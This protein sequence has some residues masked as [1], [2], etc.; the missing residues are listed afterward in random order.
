MRAKI[1]FSAVAILNERVRLDS[2]RIENLQQSK[3]DLA[4]ALALCENTVSNDKKIIAGY[5]AIAKN[6]KRKWL[7]RT[8]YAGC[9]GLAAGVVVG[10]IVR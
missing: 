7:R 1:L 3:Q 6:D 5:K 10:L 8:F 4:K 2:A 9:G